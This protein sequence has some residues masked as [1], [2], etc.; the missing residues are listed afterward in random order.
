MRILDRGTTSIQDTVS[1]VLF[2]VLPQ[3]MGV[4]TAVLL[5][6]VHCTWTSQATPSLITSRLETHSNQVADIVVAC[7]YLAVKMQ[8][9]AAIIVFVTVASYVPLTV[10][11][12]R[13]AEGGDTGGGGWDPPLGMDPCRRN[14]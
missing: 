9:W 5:T 6:S 14:P 1:I 12:R 7:T 13:G 8:P 10:Q 3:V 11:S 4:H 2:N